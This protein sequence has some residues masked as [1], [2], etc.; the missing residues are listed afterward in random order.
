MIRAAN[1]KTPTE[2]SWKT[3]MQL[4]RK[5]PDQYFLVRDDLVILDVS[6][7]V[8]R[9]SSASK[10]EIVGQRFHPM[11]CSGGADSYRDHLCQMLKEGSVRDFEIRCTYND[12]SR[13]FIF[14]GAQVLWEVERGTDLY[15]LVGRDVSDLA[16]R[17]EKRE[18]QALHDPLT[19]AFNRWYLDELLR[20]EEH[21][22][23][24]HD[25]PI[26]FLIIDVDNFKSINDTYGHLVGD[27]ILK[28]V[29]KKLRAAVRASD[30]V[31][32]FGGDEFLVVM[33]ESNGDVKTFQHRITTA[34]AASADDEPASP[35]RA[36]VS[37]GAANWFPTGSRSISDVI[38]DAD[39]AMYASRSAR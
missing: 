38:K 16:E 24:R 17:A 3:F 19:G 18:F 13:T 21:R 1:Q 23:R 37:I 35:I 2:S 4:V 20:R 34:M 10:T 5:L 30:Y 32:R 27:D 26:S 15:V 36:S 29:S 9:D 28:S 8:L 25:Q 12:T 39:A 31:V 33:P 11:S 7:S 14:C 6:D 22:G